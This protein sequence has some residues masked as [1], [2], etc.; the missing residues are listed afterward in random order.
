MNDEKDIKQKIK[1]RKFIEYHDAGNFTLRVNLKAKEWHIRPNHGESNEYIPQGSRLAFT[2]PRDKW[3]LLIPVKFEDETVLLVP[4]GY[5][6]RRYLDQEEQ[7]RF[8]SE[9][10]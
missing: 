10:N 9:R 4:N 8:N 3:T 6:E 1:K 2:V 7:T 5:L